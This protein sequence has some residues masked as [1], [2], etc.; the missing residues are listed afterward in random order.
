M[1]SDFHSLLLDK[2]NAFDVDDERFVDPYEHLSRQNLARLLHAQQ[3]QDLPLRQHE[4][5]VVPCPFE[6]E[7]L[8]EAEVAV[9]GPA[10]YEDGLFSARLRWICS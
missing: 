2:L 4:R 6:K 7:N 9:S 3:G 10:L 5:H 8:I 1:L